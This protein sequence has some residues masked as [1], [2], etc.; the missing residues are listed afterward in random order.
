MEFF[1]DFTKLK[2]KTYELVRILGILLD[3]AIEATKTCN[4]KQINMLFQA[5]KKEDKI[6]ISNTYQ[7]SEINL[8]EIFEKGFS[9]KEKNNGL[10]LWEIKQILQRNSNLELYTH[11]IDNVFFQELSI[12]HD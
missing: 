3:N 12:Y 11:K 5:G 10:G 6:K 9:T 1:M 8:I 7:D 2:V 4:K